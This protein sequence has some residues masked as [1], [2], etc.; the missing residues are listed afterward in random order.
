[1]NH[2]QC[3]QE[4]QDK[5]APIA[6]SVADQ[7]IYKSEQKQYQQQVDQVSDR[8]GYRTEHG[9]EECGQLRIKAVGIIGIYPFGVLGQHTDDT[10][11]QKKKNG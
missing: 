8:K 2:G 9:P 4:R 10:D 5:R 3:C 11:L 1:M 7:Q 6:F